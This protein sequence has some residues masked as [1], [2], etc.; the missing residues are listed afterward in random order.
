MTIR[1]T[2]DSVCLSVCS[3]FFYPHLRF[4]LFSVCVRRVPSGLQKKAGNKH[5]NEK[6]K[7]RPRVTEVRVATPYLCCCVLLFLSSHLG[8]Y[9][10]QIFVYNSA[11]LFSSWGPCDTRMTSYT[12]LLNLPSPFCSA[13]TSLRKFPSCEG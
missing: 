7:K 10:P 9:S 3:R 2:L 12:D 13:L 5:L 11:S 1:L 8:L 6:F 4:T